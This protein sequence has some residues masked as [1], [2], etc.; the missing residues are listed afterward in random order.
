MPWL[1]ETRGFWALVRNNNNNNTND[2][3]PSPPIVGLLF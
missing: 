3:D 1:V 2:P